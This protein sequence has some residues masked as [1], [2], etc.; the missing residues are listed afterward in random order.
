MIRKKWIAPAFACLLLAGACMGTGVCTFA[1]SDASEGEA[2]TPAPAAVDE[3]VSESAMETEAVTEGVEEPETTDWDIFFV[4]D[5]ET[6]VTLGE[7]KGLDIE[8]A[9]YTVTDE[10]I[11]AEIDNR[12]YEDMTME[13]TGAPAKEGDTVTADITA[14]IDGEDENTMKEEA[15]SLDLGYEFFGPEFDAQLTGCVPGDK[16]NF[17]LSFDDDFDMEEWAGQTI[18]FEVNVTGVQQ[19]ATPTLSDEW[20]KAHSECKDVEEYRN[21]VREE[22]QALY[23]AQSE[24]TAASDAFSAAMALATYND[25]PYELYLACYAQ[26][27]AQFEMLS[28]MF[29]ISV[30]ELFESYGMSEEDLEEETVN[31]VDSY[32]FMSAIAKKE[33]IEVTDDDV[34]AFVEKVYASY[35]YESPEAMIEET[36]E[37]ELKLAT[38]NDMVCTFLLSQSNVTETAYDYSESDLIYED[39]GSLDLYDEDYDEWDDEYIT[40]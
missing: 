6:Y 16:L 8:K 10:D 1:S 13:D 33:G 35:D 22:L 19:V 28:D 24:E 11:D 37:D 31:M 4:Q 39:S 40:E 23:D 27:Y 12:L 2:P 21:V 36:G 34:K 25:Y 17:T 18:D 15:Y 14:T 30:E 9:M 26:V 5:P 29:G 3:S 20:V 32:L 38:L 7:Y